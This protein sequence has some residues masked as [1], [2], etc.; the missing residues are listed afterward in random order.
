MQ[1]PNLWHGLLFLHGHI[2]DPAL[3][4]ALAAARGAAPAARSRG[5][6]RLLGHVRYLG[7]RPMHAGHNFDVEE[8]LVEAAA[9]EAPQGAPVR[10]LAPA[11][12]GAERARQPLAC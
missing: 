3:A 12:R 5:P 6:L 8:P 11:T 9:A 4:R 7:G 1:S 10:A 2:A